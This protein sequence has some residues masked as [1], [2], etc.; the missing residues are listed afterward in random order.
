MENML[1]ENANK[2]SNVMQNG[3]I[4]S[5]TS[6]FVSN[7]HSRSVLVSTDNTGDIYTETKN[8]GYSIGTRENIEAW[9]KKLNKRIKPSKTTTDIL[10]QIVNEINAQEEEEL[11]KNI[12]NQIANLNLKPTAH[13]AFM[14]DCNGKYYRFEENRYVLE[15]SVLYVDNEGN[16]TVQ[17]SLDNV[18]DRLITTY[19]KEHKPILFKVVNSNNEVCTSVRYV[20]KKLKMKQELVKRY[21]LHGYCGNS[22][23]VSA[24]IRNIFSDPR[25]TG[26]YF[27]KSYNFYKW[28]TTNCQFE[29]HERKG[30]TP[31]SPMIADYEFKDDVVV[32]T[33]YDGA[34]ICL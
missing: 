33:D 13:P 5:I 31:G 17:T 2:I 28:N 30:K 15:Q 7:I 11:K 14:I 26:Y 32:R 22:K 34:G 6:D 9:S 29:I 19:S 4:Q 21:K 12:K 23:S 1:Y 20:A 10:Q 8:L 16:Y 18:T 24:V 25:P 27:D 3:I